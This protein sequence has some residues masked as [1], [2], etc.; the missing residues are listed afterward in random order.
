MVAFVQ[1]LMKQMKCPKKEEL[2]MKDTLRSDGM[3]SLAIICLAVIIGQIVGGLKIP[4]IKFTL[5]NTG[6][7]LVSAILIGIIIK[8]YVKHINISPGPLAVYRNFGLILF[9]VGTGVSSGGKISYMLD[10]K[11]FMYG[12]LITVSTMLLGFIIF[13][14]VLKID[15]KECMLIIA[16][17]MTSTP[18]IGIIMKHTDCST[19][20][21]AY[22]VTYLG[23]MITMV[24]GVRYFL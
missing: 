20:M 6:G 8:R 9:F 5:G 23:A 7:I 12:A 10:I 11:W 4:G 21:S 15:I 16:G 19:D 2:L 13:R 14:Y 1:I 18:A 3:E 22:S 17:G 24:F